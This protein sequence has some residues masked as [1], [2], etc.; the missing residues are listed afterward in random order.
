MN[1]SPK[2]RTD[3]RGILSPSSG[4]RGPVV[5]IYNPVAGRGRRQRF[6]ATMRE[7]GL[8]GFDV[9]ARE[10]AKR[11]DAEDFARAASQDA[12]AIVIAAGGDGTVN[13][14]VNGL[15][16]GLAALAVLPLGTTNVLAAEI[17]MPS[18]PAGFARILASR[19]PRPVWPGEIA[20]RRFSL[21]VS[22]GFDA[23]VVATLDEAL[24]RRLGKAAYVVTALRHLARHR[25][26]VYGITIDGRDYQAGAAIVA[27][28]RFYGG[29]FVVAPAARIAAPEFHVCMMSGASKLDVVRYTLALAAGNLPS[30]PDVRIVAGREVAIHG[31]NGEPVQG[32]GDVLGRLPVT[33]RIASTPLS[34][35][36]P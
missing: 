13:E 6:D 19:S 25:P 36:M 14:V 1:V 31:A 8:Q 34:L 24:K 35:V 7:L 3:S 11:G 29:R 20:G 5:A 33:V 18:D 21:M 2:F 15:A 27:K 17:G 16:G 9:V 23:H 4:G 26:M 22:V 30:L 28:G 32:D 12:A 10:T